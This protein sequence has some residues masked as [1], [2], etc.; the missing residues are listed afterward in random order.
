MKLL[1]TKQPQ[2]APDKGPSLAE[3]IKQARADAEA[4]IEDKVRSLKVEHPD[5]SIEWLRLNLRA[6]NRVG[7]CHCALALK[8]LE[9]K[10]D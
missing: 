6:T 7:G 5:L 3:R 1:K 2:E 10:H 9:P 8:L 4:F